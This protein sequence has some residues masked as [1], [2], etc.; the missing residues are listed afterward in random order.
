MSTLSPLSRP[1]AERLVAEA[2][3]SGRLERAPAERLAPRLSDERVREAVLEGAHESK[4]R[5]KGDVVS[6]S[7]NVFIPLTNLCRDRCAYCT[8]AK[9]PD[10]AEARTYTLEEV[11]DVVRGGAAHRLRR[12]A[13]LPRRQARDRLPLPPRVARGAR[14]ATTAEYLVEACRVAFEGGMLPHTNA[15]ILS[16]AEMADAAALERVDRPDARV[17]ERAAAR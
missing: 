15:G 4:R 12:G 1:E 10:S 8:F 2:V 7:R 17:D 5:G 9:P 11:A 16:A 6:V 13:L 3:D 14:V